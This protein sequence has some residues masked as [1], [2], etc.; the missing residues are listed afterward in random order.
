[1]KSET[2][3]AND[4]FS[5]F[6]QIQYFLDEPD[7]N[8]SCIPLFFLSK[9]AAKDVKVVMSGEGADE[10]F[11]GYQAYG[12]WTKSRMIRLIAEA[13]KKLPRKTRKKIAD[14][15]RDKNFHGKAHLYTSIA[16]AED[17]F[18]GDSRVFEPEEAT[19]FLQADYQD[20]PTIQQIIGPTYEKVEDQNC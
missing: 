4:A 5:H 9:L 10:L 13:L 8:F 6:A 20:A 18:I 19:E 11:G 14:S 17:F 3:D 7:S 1:M 2:I 16:P 15:I 12:F